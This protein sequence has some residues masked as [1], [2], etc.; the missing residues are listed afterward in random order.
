MRLLAQMVDDASRSN[1][2][3]GFLV[4]LAM[5]DTVA[6]HLWTPFR[7][8]LFNPTTMLLYIMV[9]YIVIC[10]IYLPFFGLS[11]AVTSRGSFVVFIM[12]IVLGARLLARTITF[13]GGS[14]SMHKTISADFIKRF[15]SHLEKVSMVCI[16]EIMTCYCF[17]CCMHVVGYSLYYTYV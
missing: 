1:G 2:V 7:Y 13:P 6:D 15:S 16:I 11:Y 8:I 12:L 3:V 4:D 14:T 17:Y 9:I 5:K 10:L